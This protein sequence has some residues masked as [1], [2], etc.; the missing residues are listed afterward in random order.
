MKYEVKIT[1]QDLFDSTVEEVDASELKGSETV[2]EGTICIWL[3][4]D[5]DSVGTGQHGMN[6][7][8]D[9]FGFVLVPIEN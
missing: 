4:G 3:K 2:A 1:N 9:E 5:V 7:F 8:E 6:D